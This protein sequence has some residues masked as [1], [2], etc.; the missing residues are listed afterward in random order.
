M[1]NDAAVLLEVYR[2][3]E[4]DAWAYRLEVMG[5]LVES[6]CGWSDLF[7]C[8]DVAG[9]EFGRSHRFPAAVKRHKLM[10]RQEGVDF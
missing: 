1:K 2:C 8:C 7:T 3:P 9:N 5:E 10:E 4:H 6:F